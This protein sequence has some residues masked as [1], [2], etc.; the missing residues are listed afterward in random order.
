[1]LSLILFSAL[2][3]AQIPEPAAP[4]D[5][6]CPMDPEV[7]AASPGICSRCGMKLRLGVADH[8]E[9]ALDLKLQPRAVRTGSAAELIFKIAQP[10]TGKPVHDFEIVHEKLFHLFIVSED[11]S[12]FLHEHPRLTE[13]Y[14]FRFKTC[15]PKPGMYRLLCDFYPKG[16][17]PQLLQRTLLIPDSSGKFSGFDAASLA[18]DLAEKQASNLTVEVSTQPE[19]PIA[20]MKTLMF[21]HLKPAEGLEPYLGVWA[22]MLAVSDDLIDVM[23]SHPFRADGRPQIQFNMIFPRART[24]K[25]WVQFQRQGIVNTVAFNVPVSVLR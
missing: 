18:P 13:D 20:G 21:F 5:Y 7:R 19:R 17:T 10:A 23:H 6:V 2:F 14:S 1:M 8:L 12:F 25:V 16:G 4:L 15:F 3:A 24:Y 9:Y 11:L 22:H